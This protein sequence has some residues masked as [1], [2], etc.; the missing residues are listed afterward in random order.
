MFQNDIPFIFFNEHNELGKFFVF[1]SRENETRKNKTQKT[2]TRPSCF[3][4]LITSSVVII[5][6][7]HY[8]NYKLK[9]KNQIERVDLH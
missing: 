4:F 3:I 8:A 5:S 1:I 6:L 9:I 7:F 2:V